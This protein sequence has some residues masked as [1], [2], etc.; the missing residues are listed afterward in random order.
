MCLVALI[1][2]A[3]AAGCA[4]LQDDVTVRF[5]PATSDVYER[6]SGTPTVSMT[7]DAELIEGGHF[8]LGTVTTSRV[9][10]ECWDR[11]LKCEAAPGSA[12]VTTALLAEAR[13]QGAD[14]VVLTADGKIIY[15]SKEKRGR[16]LKMDQICMNARWNVSC[17]S[18]Q[19]QV[20]RHIRCSERCQKVCTVYEKIT[21]SVQLE[22]SSGE[23]W[24]SRAQ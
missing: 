18:F 13:D 21:G 23:L 14:V 7:S 2:V 9:V 1:P 11:P 4:S 12:D 17:D 22:T 15:E 6:R 3:F 16:C 10:E 8:H 19:R 24:R 20:N 5:D